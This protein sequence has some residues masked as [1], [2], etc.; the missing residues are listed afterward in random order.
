VSTEISDAEQE[1]YDLRGASLADVAEEI[2]LKDEAAQTEWFPQYSFTTTGQQ[3]ATADVTVKMRI[4][5]PRWPGYDS[6][7]A[8]DQSEW[9]R[10]LAA[11]QVHEQGHVD[12][13]LQH[14]SN[15]DEQ[16]VGQSPTAARGVWDETLGALKSASDSYD[17]ETNHGRNQGTIIAASGITPSAD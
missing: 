17:R 5:M 1:S 4:T 8:A 14:L 12:L 3:L 10:F 15:I 7:P 16:L 11:L 9:D 6:A 13:V 2:A